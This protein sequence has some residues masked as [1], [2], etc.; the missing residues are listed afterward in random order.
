MGKLP[1]RLP[2]ADGYIGPREDG[3]Q[4][5]KFDDEISSRAV[6][7]GFI[8]TLL[9]CAISFAFIFGWEMLFNAQDRAAAAEAAAANLAIAERIDQQPPP[10]PWLQPKPEREW[11]AMREEMNDELTH[12]G[13][14]DEAAGTVHIPIDRAIEMMA[15]KGLGSD[16]EPLPAAYTGE[17]SDDAAAASADA[18]TTATNAAESDATTPVTADDS[19]ADREET[20]GE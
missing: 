12:F 4:G 11:E 5:R 18:E 3:R 10:G 6:Y 2:D 7:W 16:P 14:V 15:A 13:W 20:D 1:T 9:A 17:A 19:E 8:G